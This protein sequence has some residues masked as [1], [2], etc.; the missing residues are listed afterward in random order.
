L[1]FIRPEG[2]D[3]RKKIYFTGDRHAKFIRTTVAEKAGKELGNLR[4]VIF[5]DDQNKKQ[6]MSVALD[7][8]KH[9]LRVNFFS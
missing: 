8:V 1:D 9:V 5:Q 6:R 4:N 2:S 7:A 3:R